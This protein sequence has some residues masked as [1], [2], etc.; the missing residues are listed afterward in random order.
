MKTVLKFK[1][2]KPISSQIK[3]KGRREAIQF[4]DVIKRWLGN[5]GCIEVEV[6]TEERTCRVLENSFARKADE[7]KN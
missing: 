4:F 6:D 7:W 5:E 3:D 2:Y 1:E